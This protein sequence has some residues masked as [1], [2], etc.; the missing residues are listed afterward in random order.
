MS[1]LYVFGIGGTGS[2]VLKALTMLLASGVKCGTDTIV[3]IIIDP[4]A[5]AADLTRSVESIKR[6]ISIRSKLGFSGDVKNRFFLTE[7]EETVPNFKLKLDNT[8]DVKFKDYMSVST[9]SQSNKALINMLFSQK[10]LEADMKVGFKGNPN[11]GSIVLN[12]FEESEEFANFAN[13]F[14]A[15]DKIF[16]ISSIFGGTGASGFPLLAK[17]LRSNKNIP[18]HNIINNAQMGAITVLPYFSVKPDGDSEIDSG[19]FISK[20]KAA[21]AYYLN[22]ISRNNTLD[23]LYYI[24][25]TQ[26][27]AYDNHEGGREQKNKAHLIELLSALAIIDF[28]NSTH[29]GNT[30]HKE[31]GLA[32]GSNDVIFGDLGG[33]TRDYLQVPLTQFMLFSNYFKHQTQGAYLDQSWAKNS[34]ID[35]SFVTSG[36]A[37]NVFNF[38]QEFCSWLEEMANNT[39]K[40]APYELSNISRAFDIVKGEKTKKIVSLSSNYALYDSFLNSYKKVAVSPEQQFV[41][42]FYDATKRLVDKKYNF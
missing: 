3:P 13:N 14:T 27:E 39:R 37:K 5:S 11:I 31:Y 26:R 25:D 8:Q 29:K 6:Y 15:N 17:M 41:E 42:L 7:I 40:F 33:E 4:D 32:Q 2:R 21:L 10:N 20:A 30:I 1:K 16:I 28:S 22:N 35:K 34:K 24:A 18:N 38:Q 12:Q 9:M 36:Y 23:Q 19:T